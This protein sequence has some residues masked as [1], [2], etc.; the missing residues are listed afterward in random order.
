MTPWL[1]LL[2]SNGSTHG[3]LLHLKKPWR[4]SKLWVSSHLC[5]N[6][7]WNWAEYAESQKSKMM[8]KDSP[9]FVVHCKHS[10]PLKIFTWTSGK[11]HSMPVGPTM[12]QKKICYP[13]NL[14]QNGWWNQWQTC[15]ALAIALKTAMTIEGLL[16]H[17]LVPWQLDV[18]DSSAEGTQ[19]QGLISNTLVVGMCSRQFW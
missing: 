8:Q 16:L 2:G 17:L 14:N 13:S 5:F 12:W 10:L 19:V 11:A 18:E 3:P 6:L 4:V 7:G 15:L 9:R 1:R